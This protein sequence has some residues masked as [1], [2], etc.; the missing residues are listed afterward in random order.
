[1][2]LLNETTIASILN[3]KSSSLIDDAIARRQLEVIRKGFNY[4]Y[5]E[6]NNALYI[7]DEVGLG[8]TYIALG[9][10]SLLRHFSSN[11]ESYQD[12]IIVPK[13]NLQ[14]KWQ[15]EIKQFINNN[16]LIS[17][18]RVK[19]IINSPVGEII[20]KDDLQAIDHDHPA[21]HLYRNSQFSL[22]LAYDSKKNLLESLI[23]KLTRKEAVDILQRAEALDYLKAYRKAHLKKLFAYLLSICNPQI[24]LLIVDE[25]HNFKYGLGHGDDEAVSDRNS[26]VARFFGIKRNTEEDQQIFTDFPELKSLVKPKVS[27]LIVLSATPKTYNLLEIKHQLDC[28]LSKHILSGVRKETEVK[29]RLSSFLIRGNMEYAIGGRSYSRNLCRFE[30]R[31]GNV[32][33]KPD[34]KPLLIKDNEQAI[35]LG[36]L[37]Y[38]TI[39]HLNAKHNASFE[40]GMLAG[41]ETFQ[42]D[43]E[44]KAQSNSNQQEGKEPEY[45][46]IRTRR[47]KTSQDHDAIKNILDSYK[48]KFGCLPPHPKQ[49]ALVDAVF[50]MMLRGEKSLIFIRRVASAKEIER[51][52][53]DK[54]EEIVNQE[55]L[56][57]WRNVFPSESVDQLVS[58][59]EEFKNNQELVKCLDV[60]F[61]N[62]LTK[63]LANKQYSFDFITDDF[64]N[65]GTERLLI[66]GLHYLYDNYKTLKKGKEFYEQLCGHCK[67]SFTRTALV[68]LGYEL[69]KEYYSSWKEMVS[70]D[71]T[72]EIEELED[73]YFFH[74]YFQRHHTKAFKKRL[75]TTDWFDVN[76]HLL[77]QHFKIASFNAEAL[78]KD[79]LKHAKDQNDIKEVQDIFIKNVLEESFQ[80]QD[81]DEELYPNVLVKKSTLLTELFIKACGEEFAL[82]LKNLDRKRKA[83]IFSEIKMLATIIK[84]CLRNGAGFLP[85]YIADKTSQGDFIGNYL[86][87]ISDSDSFFSLVLREIKSILKDYQLIKAVN[88][89][90][91]ESFRNNE[92]KLYYQSPVLGITGQ[93]KR[94]KSNVA[95]QFRM[96]GFPYVLITTDI[97]REGE[98]L[99]TYCQNIFHYGIAWNCS[100][101][102]QRTGRIDRIN[103]MSHRGLSHQNILQFENQVQVF[104]PYLKN[105]LEVNQVNRLFTSINSFVETFNDFTDD[106]KED[107]IAFT[108]EAIE[109]VPDVIRKQLN[110]KFEYPNFTGYKE[111]GHSLKLNDRLGFQSDE[112]NTFLVRLTANIS[113]GDSFYYEPEPDLQNFAIY[114]DFILKSRNERRGPFRISIKND[115]IPG[116]FIVEAASYL[117][118]VST[119]VQ[120]AITNYPKNHYELTTIEDLFALSFKIK[121]DEYNA[122][123]FKKNLLELI[124]VADQIEEELTKGD[125]NVFGK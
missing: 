33:K 120:K 86:K 38:N 49:D 115:C 47:V 53:L 104:Y 123:K 113:N 8:K 9:I 62:V 117:F 14:N 73:S 56:T 106:I 77:N 16:F 72:G 60:I 6:E 102:E 116:K 44:R 92:T 15:K 114:G 28:F 24:E 109:E 32:D 26:V 7:A 48:N 107:G 3:L 54:L 78:T 70:S 22:S 34:G 18:N 1:M 55:L 40:I 23:K 17:D 76:Y 96:P 87:I 84:S 36:L 30:H 5:Q 13:S 75:Y 29:E 43:Q 111:Y 94:N 64:H 105:T 122:E 51:R 71:K 52:F 50:K 112:L 118:K 39:K 101:M 93:S 89:P 20:V 25:G 82:F 125:I 95:T 69:L 66:T 58:Y 121:L 83:D 63:L 37:Q 41:F 19:S 91:G 4:L 10:A 79:S 59:Y 45:E 31:K 85:L 21:Y 61:S 110:S 65:L 68:D 90:D 81:L 97:F 103:S 35:V 2:N 74:S 11:P 42:L 80:D 88:F 57:K 100:D 119:R 46:E 12:V 67:I 98:D 108:D 124:E 99:H 27:K